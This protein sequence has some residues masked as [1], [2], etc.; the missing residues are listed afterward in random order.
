MRSPVLEIIREAK[1]EKADSYKILTFPTHERYETQLCKTGHEFYAFTSE[2][3]KKWDVAYADLPDNYYILPE[4]T[5]FGAI[6]FDAI[7]S[8]SKFG[9]FQIAQQLQQALGVP[10]ISLEHTLPIPDWPQGQKESMASMV[11]QENIFISEYSRREWGVKAPVKSSVIHHSVDSS[12]FKPSSVEKK[13]YA[14]SVVNDFK[15]RDYCCNYSGW[16]RV[17]DS[18][19]TKVV[20]SCSEGLSEPAPSIEALVNE[21]NSAQVFLNTSTVSP[22]PTSLLEA[23][24]CGCAVVTT[25]TCMI[26]EIIVNGENGFMSNDEAELKGYIEQLFSD[27]NL[28]TK[29]GK[30]ARET[31]LNNF[32]EKDFINNWNDTFDGVLK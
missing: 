11:G 15:N 16:Q 3:Q 22:V 18:I 5:I 6:P 27:E 14:L 23:M 9:Q 31:I 20:G 8:Q 17:T 24:S 12:L 13:P 1:L 29:L 30:A 2:G 28:R 26:P 4:G 7:L 10:I 19:E 32:S 21:Y 25:A